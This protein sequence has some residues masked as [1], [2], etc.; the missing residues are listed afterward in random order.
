[1]R[2]SG[3]AT[4]ACFWAI[5]AMRAVDQQFHS[6]RLPLERLR[7][8]GY[9]RPGLA[10]RARLDQA[11]H[12]HWAAGML[13]EQQ[14]RPRASRVPLFVVPDEQWNQAT[15]VKWFVSYRPD[16]VLGLDESILTWLGAAGFR[17]PEGVGFVHLD[18]PNGEWFSGI[19]RNGSAVGTAAIDLLVDMIHRNERGVPTLPRWILVESNWQDGTTLRTPSHIGYRIPIQGVLPYSPRREGFSEAPCDTRIQSH[20]P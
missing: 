5:I 8:L 18:C 10:V 4:L 6:M 15:F 20:V 12:N 9:Q 2:L 16:V 3:H 1:M 17:V 11:A 19:R 13:V 14:T 7:Q